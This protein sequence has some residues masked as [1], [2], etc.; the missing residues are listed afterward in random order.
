MALSVKQKAIL[1]LCIVAFSYAL[2]S[3]AVRLMGAGFGPF[4]QVYLRI[5]LGCLL[6][7]IF[8]Y[9]KIRFSRFP[10]ISRRDWLFL[11]LMGTLGYGLSVDFVTLG[12]LHTKLLD[13]AVIASTTP[14]FIFLFS[15][16]VL[17][18][19]FHSYLLF[20]LLMAFYGVCVLATK[21]LLPIF[22]QFGSGDF[23]V[24]L[25]AIGL[26][27]YIFGRKMLSAYLNNYEIAL[28]VM[29][30]AFLSSFMMAVL[31]K[32]PLS[33]A[34]FFNPYALLGFILGGVLNLVATTLETFAFRHINAVAGSQ[35]LLLENVFAPLFG[36]GFYHEI[37]LPV[38][39][40][41]ALLVLAGVWLYIK[42]GKD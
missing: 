22:S 39:F 9:K 34:G 35:L 11:L 28:I 33:I 31:V 10:R 14:F 18:K 3:V 4:T 41:G 25:F 1:A 30:I 36:Y 19:A 6:T 37:I 13:V 27:I 26:G 2:L 21:L 38:E 15:V 5:G 20:F 42:F 16:V 32:E 24:L 7:A 23:F 40:F 29:L 8:F 12:T 17:R